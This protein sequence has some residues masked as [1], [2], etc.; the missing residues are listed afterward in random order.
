MVRD[1]Y[2]HITSVS[3]VNTICYNEIQQRTLT[4]T[5]IIQSYNYIQYSLEKLWEYI[6]IY[7]YKVHLHY[8][9]ALIYKK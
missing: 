3:S 6:Y 2:G 5:L 9:K 7:I 1:I 8:T 4:Q